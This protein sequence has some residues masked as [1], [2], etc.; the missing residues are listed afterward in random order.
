MAIKTFGVIGAGQMGAGI[1]QVA[2]MRAG[3]WWH[4]ARRKSF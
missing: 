1:T 4:P 2:A 3:M